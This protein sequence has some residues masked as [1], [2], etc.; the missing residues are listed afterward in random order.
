M[1]TAFDPLV[2]SLVGHG[3]IIFVDKGTFEQLRYIDPNIQPRHLYGEAYRL[4]KID[5]GTA[6][7]R[8]YASVIDWLPERVFQ[9]ERLCEKREI[10]AMRS[11]QLLKSIG[12][13]FENIDTLINFKSGRLFVNRIQE[14]RDNWFSLDE[15][16]QKEDLISTISDGASVGQSA[17]KAWFGQSP[18]ALFNQSLNYDQSHCAISYFNGLCFISGEPGYDH[19]Q[20]WDVISLP[21]RWFDHF[22]VYGAHRSSLGRLINNSCV[23]EPCSK[24]Y[25]KVNYSKFLKRKIDICAKNFQWVRNAGLNKG[26][27]RFGFMLKKCSWN[28]KEFAILQNDLINISGMSTYYQ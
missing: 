24:N 5:E 21:P 15:Q 6:V 1:S 10:P 4:G 20:K 3:N 23:S 8:D 16:K 11:L 17:I 19:S 25:L 18:E 14:L 22:R 13:T 7:L 12:Y 2:D 28:Q 9:L 27:F 26:A